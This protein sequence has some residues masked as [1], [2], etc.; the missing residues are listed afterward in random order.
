MTRVARSCGAAGRWLAPALSVVGLLVVAIVTLSLL[1]NNVPFVGSTGGRQ[2]R[3][4]RRTI[5]ADA[6]PAPSNVVVVPRGR[7]VQ[8]PGHDRLREGRQHLDPDGQG[9]SS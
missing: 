8:G 7:G 9:R 6:T 5:P 2:R 3:R 1:G 4:Q